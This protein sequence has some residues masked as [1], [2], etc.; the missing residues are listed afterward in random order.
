MNNLFD[1]KTQKKIAGMNEDF[2]L[3]R[4]IEQFKEKRYREKNSNKYLVGKTAGYLAQI[5][6]VFFSIQFVF[7]NFNNIAPT[8]LPE[9]IQTI[10]LYVVA[11]SLLVFVEFYKRA[12]WT[13]FFEAI[14]TNQPSYKVPFLLGVLSLSISCFFAQKGAEELTVKSID[15]TQKISSITN[16]KVKN[17]KDSLNKELQTIDSQIAPLQE[18]Q[19]KRVWGLS[20]S[21]YQNLRY[22]QSQK[23]DI[24]KQ[25]ESEISKVESQSNQDIYKNKEKT[26]ENINY[27]W[28][29]ALLFECI[30]IASIRYEIMYLRNVY[31]EYNL[32][33][34]QSTPPPPPTIT[35]PIEQDSIKEKMLA[36]FFDFVK[37]KVEQANRVAEEPTINQITTNRENIGF[38]PH[39]NSPSNSINIDELVQKIIDKLPNT[40]VSVK[41]KNNTT[42]VE[43]KI[44]PNKMPYT[45]TELVQMDEYTKIVLRIKDLH[46]K[47]EK[48]R[49]ITIS[50]ELNLA[51]KQGR[52]VKKIHNAMLRLGMI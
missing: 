23:E 2:I 18:K 50:K 5:V 49:P 12:N 13:E 32:E 51:D 46:E 20:E 17:L 35:Q 27:S 38:R 40:S 15:Q 37:N 6:V 3:S 26:K 52:L 34:Q 29:W 30:A 31:F 19:G 39:N 24:K 41:E 36:M 11:I 7:E 43:K 10:V 4:S 47:G 48:I 9:K 1:N 25:F 44:L 21:E 14:S 45:D 28:F 22:L 16:E 8:L 42:I 33:L